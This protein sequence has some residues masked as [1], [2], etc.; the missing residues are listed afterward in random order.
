MADLEYQEEIQADTTLVGEAV[1]S[2]MNSDFGD[3]P[4]LVA[5]EAKLMRRRKKEL[6]HT[7]RRPTYLR[8]IEY[9]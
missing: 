5:L 7:Y 6:P 1:A 4:A 3:T 8:Y 2:D 9:V